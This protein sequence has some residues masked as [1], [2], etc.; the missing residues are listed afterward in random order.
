F[1]SWRVHRHQPPSGSVSAHGHE[2]TASP[3]SSHAAREGDAAASGGA[4]MCLALAACDVDAL[5]RPAGVI[6]QAAA[7]VAARAGV[8]EFWLNDAV[9]GFLSPRGDFDPYLELPNLRVF[10][11]SP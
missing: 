9:K 3:D 8:S 4:V 2:I 10:V 1:R 7:L 6:R 11:A 5:F